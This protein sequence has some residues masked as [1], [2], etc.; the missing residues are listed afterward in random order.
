MV[1]SI[2]RGRLKVA[3]T[4]AVAL[5]LVVAVVVSGSF[6]LDRRSRGWTVTSIRAVS[7]EPTAPTTPAPTT[8]P[9]PAPSGARAPLSFTISPI[10]I[11]EGRFVPSYADA[12]RETAYFA[13]GSGADLDVEAELTLFEPGVLKLD[14]EGAQPLSVNG[15]PAFYVLRQGVVVI[16]QVRELPTLFWVYRDDAWAM[17]VAA[18]SATTK[19]RLQELAMA[20]Q[21]GPAYGPR[22]PC[23]LTYLPPG[24]RPISIEGVPVTDE[25]HFGWS[26]IRF[27]DK[28]AGD[29]NIAILRGAAV[30]VEWQAGPYEV[31]SADGYLQTSVGAYDGRWH[32][33]EEGEPSA[34]EV[35][36]PDG[37]VTIRV[38]PRHQDAYPRDRLE[39]IALGLRCVPG[40]TEYNLSSW[41][42]LPVALGM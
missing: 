29:P 30:R 19:A 26:A 13:T 24:L 8:P 21:T 33:P 34:L 18:R 15:K 3:L 20:I 14:T 12:V 7:G 23:R 16:P 38:D 36:L 25:H 4:A 31:E 9:T 41:V 28:T 35:H 6:F 10:Q 22:L 42:D 40:G 27:A 2:S 1:V 39:R 37:I 32:R 11:G 5:V 17:L